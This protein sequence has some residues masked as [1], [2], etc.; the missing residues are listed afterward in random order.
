MLEL[1]FDKSPIKCDVFAT[2]LSQ[3]ENAMGRFLK[4]AGKNDK[5]RA[6]KMMTSVGKSLSYCGQQRLTLRMPLMR[7]HQ[8]EIIAYI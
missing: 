6:G 1:V 4:E 5:T 2:G 7:L 3:D 8:V